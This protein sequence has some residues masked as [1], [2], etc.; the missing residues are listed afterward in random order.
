MNGVQVVDGV[1]EGVC[2]HEEQ[3]KTV[4]LVAVDGKQL[5]LC[6]CSCTCIAISP[7]RV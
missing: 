7:I 6:Y 3:G 4:V 2:E 5:V 1:E